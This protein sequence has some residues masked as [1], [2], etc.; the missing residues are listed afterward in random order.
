MARCA[1]FIHDATGGLIV[2]YWEIIEA[3]PQ[4]P[5]TPAQGRRRAERQRKAQ[6]TLA[7]AQ[8]TAAIKIAAERRKLASI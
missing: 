2:R 4:K 5:L 7:D 1:S 3:M 8:A 6:A